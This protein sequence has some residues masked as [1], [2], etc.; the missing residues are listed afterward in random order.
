MDSVRGNEDAGHGD[1]VLEDIAFEKPSAARM[2]DYYL[3]GHHNFEIDRRMA[4][5]AITI[6]PDLPLIMHANRAFLRR[7]VKYLVSQGI[8]Q[9]LDI[10]SGIPTIGNVH[11]V[12]QRAHPDARIVYVDVDPVT[13]AHGQAI[14]SGDPR[15]DVIQGDFRRADRILRHPRVR[16]RL[17]FEKPVA[18]LLVAVLDFL[19]DD[20]EI[21]RSVNVLRESLTSGSYLVISHA[22]DEDRR[23]EFREHE[24]LYRQTSTPLKLRPRRN[25]ERFF[26]GFEL[27][28]PGLVYFPLW[29]P[30]GPHDLL[31]KEPERSSGF[32]GVGRRS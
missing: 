12:A 26:E 7:S 23:R 9:F 8:D 21:H 3:G 17:D 30:E 29:R 1:R 4:E 20:R 13:V 28:D 16:A 19:I 25:I 27:V 31:L 10:G 24:A 22:S 11:E 6:W 32:V 15:V 18:V 2:Y 14:L 5:R